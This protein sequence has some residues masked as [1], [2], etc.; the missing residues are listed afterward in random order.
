MVAALSIAWVRPKLKLQARL[1]GDNDGLVYLI[2][3]ITD[4]IAVFTW[5]SA[6]R[7]D[8]RKGI[9]NVLS[10]G[11]C[12][13]NVYLLVLHHTMATSWPGE[14]LSQLTNAGCLSCLELPAVMP[15][16]KCIVNQ[17]TGKNAVNC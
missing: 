3:E 11:C 8:C 13:P 16:N 17:C 10:K 14:S 12:S 4:N 9:A 6:N 1:T 7:D 2:P 5:Y 15:V